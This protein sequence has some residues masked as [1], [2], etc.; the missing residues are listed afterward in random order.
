MAKLY[1]YDSSFSVDTSIE[2]GGTHFL[3]GSQDSQGS[4]DG[5]N[6]QFTP[7]ST[8]SPIGDTVNDN[9]AHGTYEGSGFSTSNQNGDSFRYADG[10]KVP[11]AG[12]VSRLVVA[13]DGSNTADVTISGLSQS[14]VVMPD[15]DWG[16]F[17]RNIFNEADQIWGSLENGDNL[18]GYA[19]DD[20][21]IGDYGDDILRGG[22][23]NDEIYGDDKGA[24]RYR[25]NSTSDVTSY[26]PAAYFALYGDNDTLFGDAGD[27]MLFGGVGDDVLQGGTG[28]DSIDG[29]TGLNTASYSESAEGVDVNLGTGSHSGGDAAGDTLVNI[30][31]V[32]GSDHAD[33]LVGDDAANKLMG[34]KGDD[35]LNGGAGNDTLTG[36]EGEDTFELAFGM[37]DSIIT[38]FD[39]EADMLVYVG[40]SEDESTHGLNGDGDLVVTLS[41]GSTVTLKGVSEYPEPPVV[42]NY[43]TGDAEDNTLV[44]SDGVDHI[45]GFDGDDVMY[46][47][48]GG[49]TIL[50]QGG[51]DTMYGGDGNDTMEGLA[52]RDFIYG[53]GGDDFIKGGAGKDKI[54]GGDGDDQLKGAGGEDKIWGGNGD[55]RIKG[56]KKDDKIHGGEG[57]DTLRGLLDND[58]INGNNGDDTLIGNRGN[59]RL[60]GGE[61]ND[62]L[63]GSIGNDVSLGGE[64][65]DEFVFTYVDVEDEVTKETVTEGFGND[66]IKDFD[67]TDDEETINLAG[68]PG[69]SGFTDLLVNHMSQVGDS[70]VIQDGENSITLLNVSIG[71]LGTEDF[72]F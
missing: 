54:W 2:G 26:D 55:D 56:G 35:T 43:V 72:S 57:N 1:S 45:T 6:F 7:I 31:H 52:K 61:G 63:N 8:P 17:Q 16:F 38:D 39:S 47:L 68:V 64:G 12:T 23:G 37:G 50:G 15:A 71:D 69:I 3:Y 70:V 62:T 22:D 59:D 41:D 20:E 13:F 18:N 25:N 44:G 9:G 49:D 42:V 36:G 65:S 58:T 67:A 10:D 33:K 40:S 46:G 53:D 4:Y 66:I 34:G 32:E 29:G 19:G 27:D 5:N 21:I 60:N 48:D 30:Q 14:L 28:A 24:T 51:K 11:N